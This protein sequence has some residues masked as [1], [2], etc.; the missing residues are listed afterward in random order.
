MTEIS[1]TRHQPVTRAGEQTATRGLVFDID[2]FAIHDGPGIRMAV[3]MKGCPLRCQW[4]HSPESVER[5]PEVILASDRCALCGACIDACPMRLHRFDDGSH[6]FLR[7]GCRACGRCIDACPSGALAMKG[8]V[9]EAAD[10]VARAERMLPF[11]RHSGGGI[12][13]TGGEVTIQAT[14]AAAILSGCQSLGVHTAIETCGACPPE[15][16]DTLTA[17]CDLILFDIKIVDPVQH[18]K[19]TGVDNQQILH[20]IRRLP[21]DRTIVRLPLIPD[22]TDTD[23]NILAVC[24]LMQEAGLPR[25]ELLP[26]N[27]AA[28]AKYDWVGR[29]Y[30]ITGESQTP[31]RLA[32]IAGM[33]ARKDLSAQIA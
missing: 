11:F 5:Q 16:L 15:R 19:W 4:C 26:F 2:T 8:H 1:A 32:E 14:F 10:I 17:C 31:E 29:E 21:S 27:I 7:E 23:A 28:P 30:P 9:V 22:I 6:T 3:Y 13:L 18:R 20:N 33:F 24:E 25:I 12:T